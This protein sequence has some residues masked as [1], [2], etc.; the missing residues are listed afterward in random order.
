MGKIKDA[1]WDWL[2]DYGNDL[3]FDWDNYPDTKDWDDIKIN[4]TTAE[5]YY[6]NKQV[7]KWNRNAILQEDL[8]IKY[9][10]PEPPEVFENE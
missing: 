6:R 9:G 10:A 1:L 3:G 2:E 7:E 5:E 8:R 4:K